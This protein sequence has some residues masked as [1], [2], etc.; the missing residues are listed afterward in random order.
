MLG[1]GRYAGE[2]EKSE[3]F[4]EFGCHAVARLGHQKARGKEKRWRWR[5]FCN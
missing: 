4:S 3:E 5:F 1:I 2:R